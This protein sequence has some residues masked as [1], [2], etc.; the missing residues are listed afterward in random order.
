MS[1][2]SKFLLDTTIGTN[3]PSELKEKGGKMTGGSQAN[4]DKAAASKSG[5]GSKGSKGGGGSM[6]MTLNK[7]AMEHMQGVRDK[8][9]E[10]ALKE[11]DKVF[12]PP[13]EE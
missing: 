11:A 3:F 8:A 6:T 1:G 4:R 5:G 9:R 12:A 13:A 7:A 2:E 10:K